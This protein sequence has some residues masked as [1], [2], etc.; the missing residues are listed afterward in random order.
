M[1]LSVAKLNAHLEDPVLL[2][3]EQLFRESGQP[4]GEVIA[5]HGIGVRSPHDQWD[6]DTNAIWRLAE[7]NG[8]PARRR[9]ELIVTYLREK[10]E[11]PQEDLGR[12]WGCGVIRP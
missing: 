11:I 9:A 10:S 6:Q 5:E 8:S 1:T 4:L 2:I 7:P 3:A 12:L